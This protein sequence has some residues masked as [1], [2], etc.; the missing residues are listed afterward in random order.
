LTEAE[1]IE[2]AIEELHKGPRERIYREAS[3]KPYPESRLRCDLVIPGEWAVEFKLI[4][5]FGD[6][7]NEAE[8][9][10]EN[11]L[12]P[13]EG[14]TSAI[15]DCFK[16]IHSG[17]VEKKAVIVF[18]YEHIPPQVLLITAVLAFEKIASDVVRIILSDREARDF[19]PLVHPVHQLGKIFAWE[20]RESEKR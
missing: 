9:W 7:G 11:V 15:G 20:I 1:A 16:L 5:P 2:R 18:G 19:G 6:N 10:S 14:H 8:H 13:Y 17:F 3:S 12:H 4:R